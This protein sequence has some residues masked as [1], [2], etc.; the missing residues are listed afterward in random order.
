MML[1]FLPGGCSTGHNIAVKK[2]RDGAAGNV[3]VF[4]STRMAVLVV[5]LLKFG[6]LSKISFIK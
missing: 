5:G 2:N 1:P 4:W 3:D 6:R